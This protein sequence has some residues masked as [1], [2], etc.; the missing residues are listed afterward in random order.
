MLERRQYNFYIG[1]DIAKS[2]I[3]IYNSKTGDNTTIKNNSEAVEQYFKNITDKDKTLITIDKT[4]GYERTTIDTLYNNDF[5]NIITAEGLKVKNY[6]RAIKNNRAKTDKNDAKLLAEYGEQMQRQLKLYKLIDKA[7]EE[8]KTIYNRVEDLKYILQQEKNRAKQPNINDI[9][10]QSIKDNINNLQTQIAILEQQ[11]ITIIEQSK[12]QNN[13]Y[14]I[15]TTLLNQRAIAQELALFITIKI[16]EIGTTQRKQLTSIC[17]LAPIPNDSGTIT[18]HRYTQG[19]RREIKSK[20][21]FYILNLIRLKHQPIYDKYI[22][23]K[24][25]G[26]PTK[27]IITALARKQ[28]IILN[29]IVRQALANKQ[30]QIK[31]IEK[32][33]CF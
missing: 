1:V 18:K 11:I 32:Y 6:S 17:G 5:K 31:N 19:G 22:Q 26:K 7:T 29:A 28:L 12:Q 14:T 24:N 21:Y 9:L 2:K 25:K 3:D 16:N 33:S 23:M 27:V 30:Q 20:L 10:K 8:V 4:G 13:L 15:Y